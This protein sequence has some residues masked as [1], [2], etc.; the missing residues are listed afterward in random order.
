METLAEKQRKKEAKKEL[1]DIIKSNI[2]CSD[3]QAERIYDIA[4]ERA[5]KEL[6]S[7]E[8]AISNYIINRYMHCTC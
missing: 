2:K 4:E 5:K 8:L 6:C 3:I 7:I 1:L